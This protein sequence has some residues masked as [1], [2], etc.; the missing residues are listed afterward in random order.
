MRNILFISIIIILFK[1]GNVLSENN[2]FNV[3]NIEISKKTYKNKDNQISQAFQ[4]GFIE[5][6]KRLLLENDYQKLSTSTLKQIKELISYYQIIDENDEN[7]RNQNLKVNI[8][9]DRNKVHNF[10][11][12]KN[13]LY[14]DVINTEIALF[15]LFINDEKFFIYN[16]NYFYDNWNSTKY[17][18]RELIQYILPVESIEN[19]QKIKDTKDDI[20]NIDITDFFKEYDVENMVFASIEI[21]KDIA[22]IFLN[23]IID[24]KQM[25]KN[26]LIKKK[27]LDK[28]EFKD[29]IIL[30]I[31]NEIM[32]LVKSQNLIDVR[33][34][35]FLNVEIKLTNKKSNLVEF[36]N[37]V[38]KIDLIDSFNVQQL[39]K[40]YA[41]V[42]IKYL[43]N[44]TK[45]IKKLKD[46]NMNLKK[47]GDSWDLNII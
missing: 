26:L 43:G 34:P 14:S 37:R 47:T 27:N 39:N 11:Y 29:Q 46:H 32:D 30:K 17:N 2:I 40:D 38:K 12:K 42:R 13:I 28:E 18:S 33:T 45:I 9:F 31:K 15:P 21:N 23:T 44:V 7:K 6:I 1:T 22:K 3:N 20:L 10:F 41:L 4:K 35:S 25:N 36:N 5:L 24:G 19:I 16:E 8:F